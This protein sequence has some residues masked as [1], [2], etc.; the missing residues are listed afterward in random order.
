MDVVKKSS[1]FG[2]DGRHFDCRVP[3]AALP[4]AWMISN[5][6]LTAL[7]GVPTAWRVPRESQWSGFASIREPVVDDERRLVPFGGQEIVR[8]SKKIMY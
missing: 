5:V 7:G 6:P 4:F 3:R 1:V 8:I 2:R